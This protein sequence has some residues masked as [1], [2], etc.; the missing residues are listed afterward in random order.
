MP[1]DPDTI[2]LEAMCGGIKKIDSKPYRKGTGIYEYDVHLD[3]V[4]LWTFTVVA[5]SG[6]LRQIERV[7]YDIRPLE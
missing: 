5:T 6:D 4:G 3:R 2:H 1:I 7:T